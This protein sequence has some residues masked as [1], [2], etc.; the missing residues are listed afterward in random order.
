MI[1]SNWTLT[2]FL[3]GVGGGLWVYA[4]IP[5]HNRAFCQPITEEVP[6]ICFALIGSIDG[7]RFIQVTFLVH[8]GYIPV[9]AGYI[10][11]HAG[12]I[13]VHAGYII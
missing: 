9:N 4:G 2:L 13:P 8:A 12:Y 3:G 7:W 6:I 10:P 1:L 11:V 5:S